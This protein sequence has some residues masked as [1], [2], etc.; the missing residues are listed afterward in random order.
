MQKS[1]EPKKK[2]EVFEKKPKE[3][4]ASKAKKTKAEEE[5]A[6]VF[7]ATDGKIKEGGLRTALRVGKDYKFRRPVLSRLL[8]VEDGAKFE[9]DGNTFKM[10]NGLRKKIQLAVNMMKN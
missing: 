9:L 8:K 7:E 6:G 1:K 5:E 3:Y 4:P 10:T 2:G